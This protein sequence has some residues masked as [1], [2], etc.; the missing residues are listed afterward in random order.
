MQVEPVRFVPRPEN[1]HG[2][3]TY[4]WRTR[5]L[6]QQLAVRSAE[7]KLAIRASIELVALLVNGAMVAA[8]E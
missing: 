3:A 5:D 2:I 4:L 8:T 1:L 6:G 7:P